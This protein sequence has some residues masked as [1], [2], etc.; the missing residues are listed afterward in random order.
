MKI[1]IQNVIT[2]GDLKKR[3]DATRFLS[4]PWGVY[5][6]QYYGGRC[7]YIKDKTM[8]GRV[9]VFLSGKMISIGAKS[10]DES[11]KQLDRDM[12][13]LIE[14]KFVTNIKLLPRIQN[15]VATADLESRIDIKAMTT[16]LAMIT[17]EPDQ[18]P[19]AILRTLHGP[20]CLVFSTGKIFIVGSKSD[21]Q[22]LLC[23][24]NLKKIL[25][26]FLIE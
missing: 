25:K 9:T 11:I 13:L 3:V 2:T 22:L 26:D 24:N 23:S 14:N 17:Y 8:K 16:R 21:R 10:V 4:Y 15:I 18:F 7:G 20:V 6:L 5:D 19:G 1:S 12:T